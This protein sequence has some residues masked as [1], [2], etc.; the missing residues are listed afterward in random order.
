VCLGPK[1]GQ[2]GRP[3]VWAESNAIGSERRREEVEVYLGLEWRLGDGG[4][5][6][7]LGVAGDDGGSCKPGIKSRVNRAVG[8]F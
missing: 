4:A 3:F 7:V 6:E 8:S 5:L 2:G 1:Q